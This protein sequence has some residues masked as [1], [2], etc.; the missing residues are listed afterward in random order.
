MKKPRFFLVL[1]SCLL[2]GL[3]IGFAISGTPIGFGARPGHAAP[4]VPG[5]VWDA[6]PSAAHLSLW[7][8]DFTLMFPVITSAD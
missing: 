8:E 4:Q 6:F 1:I 7:Q 5:A 3:M 2:L